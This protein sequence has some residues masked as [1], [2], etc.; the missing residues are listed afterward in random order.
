[1]CL[2]KKDTKEKEAKIKE[3][4]KKGT[5]KEDTTKERTK[6]AEATKEVNKK[7]ETAK[8]ETAKKRAKKTR[9]IK[10]ETIKEVELYEP[11]REFLS[12]RGFAV[13]SEVLNC[14]V[15][16]LLEELL[17]VVEMKTSL[18]LDVVLQAVER[19][20]FAD[21]VYIAVPKNGRILFT[22]R[23][24][25]I[26]HLLRRL[27]VGLL[28]V[29]VNKDFSYVEEALKPIPFDRARSISAAQRKRKNV[30]KEVSERH[31]DYNTGGSNKKKLVTSYRES[32][33]QIAV[34]LEKLQSCSI[35]EIREAG[36]L[37]Q[38]TAKILQDNHYGWF[39]REKRGVYCLTEKGAEELKDYSELA[40]LYKDRIIES[41]IDTTAGTPAA[42]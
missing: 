28:L 5:L 19:Q 15:T 33:I 31:G 12:N 26:C 37:P 29:T 22:K 40:K 24:K 34:I 7:E 2:P 3:T 30:I 17:V 1:M 9:N 8:E 20:R 42:E 35:K 16:A 38:K 21:L 25:K 32:A 41:S 36:D 6:K 18:N 14:D 27:E 4:M 39:A 23:W 13:N 11:V 10:K